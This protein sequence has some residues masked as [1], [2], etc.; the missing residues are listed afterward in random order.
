MQIFKKI[1]ILFSMLVF[2]AVAGVG[3]SNEEGPAE[4]A[5]KS[6]DQTLQQAGE[7][8]EGAKEEAAEMLEE[9][10]DKVEEAGDKVEEAT[11]K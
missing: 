7:A 9:A 10:G 1:M 5:G 6:I 11:D 4:K 8:V 2:L 3:C